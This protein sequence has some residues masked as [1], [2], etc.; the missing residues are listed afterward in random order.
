VVVVVEETDGCPL[1]VRVS[2][3]PIF[4]LR[5]SVLLGASG[6]SFL[7]QD[8]GW[9]LGGGLCFLGLGL[10]LG[11]GWGLYLDLGT[12]RGLGVG[13]GVGVILLPY[14]HLDRQPLGF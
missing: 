10:G 7:L 9:G 12:K 3:L 14:G 5:G 4:A 11:L 2:S 8:W 1:G 6:C 13:R